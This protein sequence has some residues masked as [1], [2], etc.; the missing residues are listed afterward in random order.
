M[1]K[2]NRTRSLML[3]LPLALLSLGFTNAQSIDPNIEINQYVEG[4]LA[5]NISPLM[6]IQGTLEQGDM[7]RS[8][9]IFYDVHTFDGIQGQRTVIRLESNEFDPFLVLLNSNGDMIDSNDDLNGRNS[10]LS[11]ELPYTGTYLLG[12]SGL[13][14]NTRGRYLLTI[15]EVVNNASRNSQPDPSVSDTSNGVCNASRES[16]PSDQSREIRSVQNRLSFQVPVNYRAIAEGRNIFIFSPEAYEFNQCNSPT[17]TDF[18]SDKTRIMVEE[19]SVPSS[20]SL[21]QSLDAFIRE[22]QIN[23]RGNIQERNISRE[24]ALVFHYESPEGLLRN[25]VFFL[26]QRTHLVIISS[27]INSVSDPDPEVLRRVV[28]SLE[29]SYSITDGSPRIGIVPTLNVCGLSVWQAS[30]DNLT[31][32]LTASGGE[33]VAT[34]RVNDQLLRLA[35]NSGQILPEQSQPPGHFTFQSSDRSTTVS[36]QGNWRRSNTGSWSLNNGRLVVTRSSEIAELPVSA[37]L[38]CEFLFY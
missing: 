34:V 11:I 36:L 32:L 18:F 23:L 14:R 16:P 33:S 17:A 27:P 10:Y 25:Y 15:E 28:S 2:L 3:S 31:H 20:A 1:L 35:S 19:S 5:Q 24:D 21:R 26:P 8:S 30:N 4:Y 37:S 13:S 12:V 29:I 6:Q 22:N 9:G 7:T 38:G